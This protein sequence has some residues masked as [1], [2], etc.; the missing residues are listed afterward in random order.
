MYFFKSGKINDKSSF[1]RP[2]INHFSNTITLIISQQCNQGVFLD[3]AAPKTLN[4]PML[5]KQ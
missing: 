4:N 2:H 1:Y 3:G 5:W